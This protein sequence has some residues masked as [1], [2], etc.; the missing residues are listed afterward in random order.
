[1]VNIV[2]LLLR[3]EIQDSELSAS[4]WLFGPKYTMHG[5]W[6]FC[7]TSKH[8]RLTTY[9]V[10]MCWCFPRIFRHNI[11]PLKINVDWVGISYTHCVNLVHAYNFSK[12]FQEIDILYQL[13]VVR[14]SIWLGLIDREDERKGQVPKAPCSAPAATLKA[15]LNSLAP[16]GAGVSANTP[17]LERGRRNIF[18]LPALADLIGNIESLGPVGGWG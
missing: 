2:C 4:F 1:M 8:A 17:L 13:S 5:F 3:R 16:L 14:T 9:I 12:S 10:V 6:F 15:I 7:K 11:G 18:S